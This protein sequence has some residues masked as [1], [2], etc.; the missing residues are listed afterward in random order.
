MPVVNKEIQYTVGIEDLYLCM[1]E[2][3]EKPD[4][5]PT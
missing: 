2:G 4:A 1:M 5:L 3:D